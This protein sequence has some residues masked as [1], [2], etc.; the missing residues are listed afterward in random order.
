M[1]FVSKFY[2]IFAETSIKCAVLTLYAWVF[3]RKLYINSRF[4]VKLA[5]SL[6]PFDVE[7]C[8]EEV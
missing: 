8:A 3:V 2:C 7:C 4:S 6:V 5:W 1:P